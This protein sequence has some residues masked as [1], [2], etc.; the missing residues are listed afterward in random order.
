MLVEDLDEHALRAFEEDRSTV[1][2]RAIVRALIKYAAFSAADRK[3]EGLGAVMN[4]FNVVTETADTRS[5]ST[6]P[7]A[8]WMAR[9]DLP[10]GEYLIDA[11]FFSEDG[12]K[13]ATATFRDVQ[14]RHG[15]MV[16]K[17]ARVF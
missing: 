7:Q 5:W 12:V 2:V 13:R 17:N 3:D 14:V 15:G 4:L 1:F 8:I 6:L 16:F 10:A 11:D 9:L